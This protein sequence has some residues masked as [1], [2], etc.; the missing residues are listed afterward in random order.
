MLFQVAALVPASTL[1]DRPQCCVKDP[2]FSFQGHGLLAGARDAVHVCYGTAGHAGVCVCMC[3]CV[4]VRA[5]VRE[6]VRACVR[7]CV[8]ACVRA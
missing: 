2:G 4:C 3:V 1:L 8:R 5:C 7:G 6:C